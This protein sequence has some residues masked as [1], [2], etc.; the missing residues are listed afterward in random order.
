MFKITKKYS[1]LIPKQPY[2]VTL[3]M[4]IFDKWPF[5]T[6][7]HSISYIFC[8]FFLYY[9]VS[10]AFIFQNFA[11][12]GVGNQEFS[13]VFCEFLRIHCYERLSCTLRFLRTDHHWLRSSPL[14][15][16]TNF[17]WWRVGIHIFRQFSC[18]CSKFGRIFAQI[19]KGHLG[20]ED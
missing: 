10:L 3:K 15:F 14:T 12:G 11:I 18:S 16:L 17:E 19:P 9:T 4:Y 7:N 13:I 6:L 1:P 20:H 2:L 5:L 8:H